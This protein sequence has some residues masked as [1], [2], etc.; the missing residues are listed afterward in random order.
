MTFT[1]GLRRHLL[2]CLLLLA[3][4]TLAAPSATRIITVF[5]PPASEID[6]DG[7]V[8]GY[9]TE[10][11]R[12]L[13][14]QLGDTSRIEVMPEARALLTAA[15]YPHVLLFGFSRTPER[16]A[17][18]HWVMPLLSKRWLFYV[19]QSDPLRSAT[20]EQMKKL[21][22]IGVV[23]GDVR[24]QWLQARRFT[25]LQY[26]GSHLQNLQRLQA[27]RLRAIAYESQGMQVLQ[28][29]NGIAATEFRALLEFNSAEVWLLMSKS[30]PAAEVARW[31][32][33]AAQLRASGQ[34]LRTAE[35]W[36]QK[37]LRRNIPTTIRADGLLMF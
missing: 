23:Q 12:A 11:V 15:H 27:G 20:L 14:Q 34:P 6:S 22:S 2:L 26:S 1:P 16:E 29:D 9:A 10:L 8:T 5:E 3:T 31:Q 28:Q 24:G 25:N 30:T 17:Q 4:E 18:F 37:L 19:R 36:Q 21:E 35:K 33:A 32:Q 7:N 13:Q